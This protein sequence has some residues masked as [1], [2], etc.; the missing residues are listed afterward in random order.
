MNPLDRTALLELTKTLAQPV[1]F[2]DL[3]KRGVISKAGAW[4]RLHKPELLPE[5]ASRKIYVMEQD[6]KGVKVKFEKASKFAKLQ[7]Q[8]E[9]DL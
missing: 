8:F 2:A 6:A 3:E 4:Y 1:D 9:K 5:H 7:K